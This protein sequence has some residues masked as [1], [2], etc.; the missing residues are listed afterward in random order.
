VSKWKGVVTMI[1]KKIFEQ[2]KFYRR[3]TIK[4]LDSVSEKEADE[5]PKGFKNTIRWHLGHIYIAHENIIFGMAG[6]QPQMPEGFVDWFS[7]GTKPEDWSSEP[8]SLQELRE[9]LSSQV[10][11]IEQ[12]L[13]G[14]LQDEPVNP[15]EIP[16]Q[17]TFTTLE[18]IVNFAMYHE[19][20][21]S[22]LIKGIKYALKKE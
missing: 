5:M 19:G 21:H 7:G 22:G 11:R 10:E 15:F 13:T 3:I 18:E 16:N 8:P 20:Q 6:E 12:K 9:V 1:D 2:L 17:I 14:R 4:L